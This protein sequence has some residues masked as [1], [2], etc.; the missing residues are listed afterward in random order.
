M[1]QLKIVSRMKIQSRITE[2]EKLKNVERGKAFE[3]VQR[4]SMADPS[5]LDTAAYHIIEDD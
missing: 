4:M 1:K 3:E 5:I 2:E